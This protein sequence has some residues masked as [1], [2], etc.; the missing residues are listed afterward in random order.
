[1]CGLGDLAFEK[2]DTHGLNF[3][4]KIL[5]HFSGSIS[6]D[7]AERFNTMKQNAMLIY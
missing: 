2:K 1:M 5:H 7:L 3:T 4:L 6:Y